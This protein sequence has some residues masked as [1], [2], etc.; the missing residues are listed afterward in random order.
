MPLKTADSKDAIPESYRDAAFETKDG[1]FVYE[2]PEDVSGLKSALQK[3][4]ESR[5]AAEKLSAKLSK[6]LKEKATKAAAG[7]AKLSDEELAKVRQAVAEEYAPQLEEAAKLRAKLNE[8][9]L[10]QQVLRLIDKA[11]VLGPQRDKLWKLVKDEYDLTAEGTAILK[12]KP[13]ADIAKHIES[14]KKEY[15]WAFAAPAASGGGAKGVAGTIPAGMKAD[16]VLSNPT[17]FITAGL[18]KSA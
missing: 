14:Y 2:E 11:G 18:Q 5:E 7:E 9:Q 13:G 3:E 10:D 16:D 12:G 4:R 15:E 17:A 6:E 8:V 1:K